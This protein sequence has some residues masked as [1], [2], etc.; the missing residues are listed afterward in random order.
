MNIKSLM[1]VFL[2]Y[3]SACFVFLFFPRC[4]RDAE[5][6]VI[7]KHTT[8]TIKKVIRD[9]IHDT[10]P[11]PVFISVVD[12]LIIPV[13]DTDGAIRLPITQNHYSK[14][15]LYD[16]WVSGYQPQL[17][18]IKTYNSVVYS[19]IINETI[20]EVTVPKTSIYP[21]GGLIMSNGTVGGKIGV[22]VTTK[23][24]WLFGGEVGMLGK[25]VYYGVNIGYKIY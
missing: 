20:K 8:D 7:T 15:S 19:T 25:D 14:P 1:C 18:S 16:V 3:I 4:T 5:P 17:D 21:Y 6:S 13:P 24:S 23:K 10:I 11:T 9:T 2:G 12:T 22:A